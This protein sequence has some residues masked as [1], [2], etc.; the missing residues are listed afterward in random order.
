VR[1]RAGIRGVHRIV[2][3]PLANIVSLEHAGP[4]FLN[5]G[6]QPGRPRAAYPLGAAP[7]TVAAKTETGINWAPD[8]LR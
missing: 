1:Q 7:T 6:C 2:A 4:S 5:L 8:R 3:P